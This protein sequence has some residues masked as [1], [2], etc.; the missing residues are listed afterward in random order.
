MKSSRLRGCENNSMMDEWTK[1]HYRRVEVAT[2]VAIWALIVG[3]FAHWR[4]F[5]FVG[6]G[7]WLLAVLRAEITVGAIN[8]MNRR[9]K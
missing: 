2:R 1:A 4:E 9:R 5:H 8:K 3:L 7:L 6:Y